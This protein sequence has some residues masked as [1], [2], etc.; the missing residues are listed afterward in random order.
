VTGVDASG[1]EYKVDSPSPRSP[2]SPASPAR[3]PP[4][5]PDASTGGADSAVFALPE[6]YVDDDYVFGFT[7]PRQGYGLEAEL[8]RREGVMRRILD[9]NITNT[10]R[11]VNSTSAANNASAD[12]D[13]NHGNA[14]A[15]ETEGEAEQGQQ[16]QQRLS[17]AAEAGRLADHWQSR[18]PSFQPANSSNSASGNARAASSDAVSASP[19]SASASATA[20]VPDTAGAS[21]FMSSQQSLSVAMTV[22]GLI[23][24]SKGRFRLDDLGKED[25]VTVGATGAA[26]DTGAAGSA[27]HSG[28][29]AA[30]A[31]ETEEEA[32][33][34]MAAELDEQLE[35]EMELMRAKDAESAAFAA[36]VAAATAAAAATTTAAASE[37]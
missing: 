11:S 2:A 20:S 32:E 30:E 27:A 36:S 5:A 26:T 22:L 12:A 25:G 3:S 6:R 8:R 4:L 29:A 9:N 16:G 19:A 10:D 37:A 14:S 13:S 1:N 34:R 17:P 33:A 21:R 35:K 24:A 28:G 18:L 15:G 23:D 7:A 31:G